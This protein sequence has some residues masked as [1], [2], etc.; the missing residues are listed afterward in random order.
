MT[1]VRAPSHLPTPR[2][3][4]HKGVLDLLELHLQGSFEALH[5]GTKT[6][7]SLKEQFLFLTTEPTLQPQT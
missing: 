6:K 3:S 5:V 1:C 2:L 4:S 7:G